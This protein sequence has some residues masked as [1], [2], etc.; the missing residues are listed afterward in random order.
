MARGPH[1]HMDSK[2]R[3][4][5]SLQ[6]TNQSRL[7][8]VANCALRA[9]ANADATVKA[10]AVA[11]AVKRELARQRHRETRINEAKLLEM[12]RGKVKNWLEKFQTEAPDSEIEST[13]HHDDGSH[14]SIDYLPDSDSAVSPRQWPRRFSNQPEDDLG[15]DPFPHCNP[16]PY[17]SAN[18]LQRGF[19]MRHWAIKFDC[20][21]RGDAYDRDMVDCS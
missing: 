8:L 3:L 2:S 11:R 10:H 12:A 1:P 6:R 15:I 20:H 7:R 16:V 17:A 18:G 9:N 5:S 13:L 4:R 21:P 14:P 19:D